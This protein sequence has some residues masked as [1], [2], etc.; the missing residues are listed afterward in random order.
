M[1]Q[2]MITENYRITK[3][4]SK[5]IIKPSVPSIKDTIKLLNT[6]YENTSISALDKTVPLNTQCM[7]LRFQWIN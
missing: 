3:G 7:F 6:E 5:S 1:D 4:T 2:N